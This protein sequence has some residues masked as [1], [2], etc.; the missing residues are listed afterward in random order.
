[1]WRQIADRLKNDWEKGYIKISKNKSASNNNKFSIQY[2]PSGVIA[3]IEKGELQVIGK[4]EGVPTLVFGD[5]QTVGGQIPTIWTE[6]DFYTS[7]GTELLKKMF[8]EIVKV[9]D[10]PKALALIQSVI[11]AIS[12]ENA[13]ILDSFAGSGTTA[14]AVLNLNKEDGGNRKFI[15][16]EM[17]DYADT[18]TAERVKRD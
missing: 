16:V 8:P 17:E 1:M 13:I 9:F 4:E 10:Y 7:K 12:D 14:H 11:S 15:L 2:L 3:K 6:K 5:N 18:I